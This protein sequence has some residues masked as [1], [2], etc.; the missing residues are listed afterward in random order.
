MRA[1]EDGSAGKSMKQN[2]SG[3]LLA[4]LAVVI[5][6]GNFVVAR[7][8]ADMIPPWQCNFWRWFTAFATCARTGPP[9]AVTGASW[10]SCPCW[11]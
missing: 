2:T 10:W 11:A 3:Y 9:C 6:S 7:A 5:W 8:V 4:L 1:Q